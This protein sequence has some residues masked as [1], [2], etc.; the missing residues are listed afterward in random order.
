MRRILRYAR[1]RAFAT[2]SSTF[3]ICPRRSRRRLATAAISA[4]RVRYS[5]ESPVLGSAGGP[6]KALSL[7]PDEDFFI[8]NGDTL[9]NVD[10]HA[11]AANIARPGALVTIAVIPNQLARPLRRPD[12]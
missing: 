4:S 12:R 5:F 9:T 10:L 2:S 7:L 8:I 11:L 1:R 3:T 6:R